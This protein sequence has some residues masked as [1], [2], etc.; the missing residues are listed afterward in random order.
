MDQFTGGCLC[1]DVR[2]VATGRPY[3][4]GLCH[5][6]DCRKHHG[7]L[8][9]ASAIFA[10][11]AVTVTGET[12]D[13]RGRHFCPR[14]GSSVYSRTGDEVEVH[15]GALDAPDQ[16]TPTYELWTVRREAWLPPFPFIRHY[17]RDRESESRSEDP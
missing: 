13:F 3:R 10:Q 7:A 1:G 9:G 16:L 15:L 11:D 12:R 17:E 14:C 5:C 6:L 2:L 8:F 4:V